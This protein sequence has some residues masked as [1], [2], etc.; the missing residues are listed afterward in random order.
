MKRQRSRHPGR[1]GITMVESLLAIAITSIAGSALLSAVFGAVASS[2]DATYRNIARGLA[3]QLM[4]EVVAAPFP[5]SP[6]TPKSGSTRSSFDDVDDYHG[7]RGSPPTAKDGTQIGNE[8]YTYLTYNIPR[9]T[10]MQPDARLMDNF[11]RR[12]TVERI[13]PSSSG[14]WQTTTSPSDYRRITVTVEFTN[15]RNHT[16]IL[17]RIARIYSHVPAS[18]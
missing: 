16:Q 14:G 1:H 8:G 10:P 15:S 11:A 12:V 6:P 3:R 2:S 9:L 5:A 13:T 7:W 4:E 17:A 18:P